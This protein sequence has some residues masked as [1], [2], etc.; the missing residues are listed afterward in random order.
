MRTALLAACAAAIAVTA[1]AAPQKNPPALAPPSAPAAPGP[2]DWRTPDPNDVL[3]IDTNKGRILVEMIPEVAPQHVARM[4]E[5]AHENFFDGLRFFRVIEDFMDQTGDPQNSGQGGSSKP[6]V[7]AEFTFRRGADLPFAMAADQ[8][9]AEVGFVKS[10]PVMSQSM[11]LG[12]MTKDQKVTG[13]GLYCQ[14]VAGMARDDNPDSGNSQFFLMRGPFPSLE[15]K[16]TAW[17]RVISGQDVVKAIKVGEPVPDPQD[18]M[19][20]VRLLGDLPEKDRPKVRVIDPKGPWFKA[21]I[22]RVRAAKGADFTACNVD[23]PVEVK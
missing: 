12:A 5:L 3:V 21:E 8:T 20:R 22:E 7:P 11:M 15:K 23:I 6:N 14:G 2:A 19:E 18:R 4:R 10:L 9:V 17:G 16:Y 13:W 1:S